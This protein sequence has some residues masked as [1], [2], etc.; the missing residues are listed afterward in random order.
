TSDGLVRFDGVKFGPWSPPPGESL[1]AA[2]VGALLGARDGSLWIGT[3]SG[4]SRLRDGHLFNYTTTTRSPGIGRI[5]ED[6]AGTIWVTRYF[7]DDGMGPL[8]RVSGERL[9][10]Y[11]KQDGLVATSA[12]GLAVQADGTLW[13]ACQMVCRFAAGAFTSYFDEQLTD[14]AGGHGAVD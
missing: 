12:L 11:G 14:P 13:F 5:R 6:G 1:P 7:V 10:C 3:S 9:I 4:L 2:G 8:C